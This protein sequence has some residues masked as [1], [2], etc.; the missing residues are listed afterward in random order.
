VVLHQFIRV[1]P[2]PV[3]DF[4]K[5]SLCLV[6][7]DYALGDSTDNP[8][9]VEVVLQLPFLATLLDKSA[10]ISSGP[11]RRMSA[12]HDA[13]KARGSVVVWGIGDI[14]A[15]G[16]DVQPSLEAGFPRLPIANS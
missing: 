5:P 10:W 6:R 11:E 7:C 14:Q 8:E 1:L 12:S 13:T 15:T 9:D 16:E 4:P 2:N 3:T